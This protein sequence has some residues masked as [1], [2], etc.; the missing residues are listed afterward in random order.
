MDKD[1][2]KGKVEQARGKAQDIRGSVTGDVVDNIEGKARQVAGKVQEE[3]GKAKDTLR[4]EA[5][6]AEARDQVAHE[7]EIAREEEVR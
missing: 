1:R 2:I 3:Y 6:K 7:E 5:R 4:H